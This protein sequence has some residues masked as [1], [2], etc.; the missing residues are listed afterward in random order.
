MN[1]Y[2]GSLSK[3]V[4]PRESENLRL[5][6]QAAREG[7]VLLKNNDALPLQ[8]RS[9]ALYGM[10]A[11][12]TVK[13]GTGSGAVQERHSVSIAEG[14][15][16]AGY[17][18]TTKRYLDDYDQT[19]DA[20]YQAWHKDVSARVAG[21]PI[22]QAMGE[23]SI[24]GGF[25]WP[26]G[27]RITNQDISE[28]NTDTAIYILARQAGEGSDRQLKPGDWYLTDDEKAN[29]AL[30][31]KSYKH[32]IVVIN[33]GGQIDLS[34]MDEIDGIDALVFFVQGGMAGGD[35]LADV[36]SGQHTFC[37]KLADTWAMRYED[38]PF[39]MDYSH[40][41]GDLENEDYREGIYVGYRYFDTFKIKPR[42]PFGFGLSY[43]TFD[44]AIQ[45]VDVQQSVVSAKIE[46]RNTGS[47]YAGKEVVQLYLSCPSGEIAREAKSLVAFAKTNDLAPGQRQTL[48][49]N[50][51]LQAAAAYS[52]S[53]QAWLLEAGS[54][55]L[56][57][58]TSARDVQS[59]A[60][61]NLERNVI[62]AQCRSSCAPQVA[63]D[64]L[65]ASPAEI[66]RPMGILELTIDPN[67][68]TAMQY[69]YSDPSVPESDEQ[70]RL[71]DSF[72][73][74][75]LV[76]LVVGGD[77]RAQHPAIHAPLGS[78]GRTSLDLRGHGIG[79]IAFC[80]GPAGVNIIE[81]AIRIPS[82]LEVPDKIPEKYNFGELAEQA[83]KM[84]PPA[85][86]KHVY[87]FATAWPVELLLA[88][89]WDP[90][91]LEEI[92]RGVGREL[93]E[94][95]VTL[96]LAPGMNIH[97]N[98]LCGRN[99][100]YY[101]EDPLLTG[102]MAAA[103]TRGVQAHPGI[104]TTVK[105]FCCNNQ[106]NNRN[107]VSSNVSERALREI[108][109]KGFEIA[110]R[111]FQP[112]AVMSSYNRLNGIYTANRHDL[113][114][115]I[116]RCEWGFEGLVMTDWNSCGPKAA[117]PADCVPAGN[118]LIMPGSTA[119]SEAILAASKDGQIPSAALRRSAARVLKLILGS[120]IGLKDGI[121]PS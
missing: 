8:S 106:E 33:V 58:G 48:T 92:G 94:F 93:T 98:P 61:L 6:R 73:L 65:E 55:V 20:A 119:D 91:L 111:E 99:F 27:R 85:D 53:R 88:Q 41:N 22:M 104:G 107:G 26:S 113:L 7:F 10:G 47:Q 100:E 9:I 35:A 80:D 60:V 105:H 86:G 2:Y 89:T 64:G 23:L 49:L 75:E 77:L 82:G 57:A 3:A 108:Y 84:S 103:T 5:A 56:L 74:K 50:F 42:Y 72:S 95:G 21:M 25:Q 34:W 67:A 101:S 43:T 79:N 112:L 116:L 115:D 102:R 28:S 37:G 110:V 46:V 120:G 96:W 109:L 29:L 13:G 39:A 97:R 62:T 118:D 17:M 71:L 36:L 83:R 24:L 12:K 18:I 40:L 76:S 81:E 19:Y 68:F 66:D 87:R 44:L 117:D 69:D 63:I 15:E 31:A 70:K 114:T 90:D 14:L 38:I 54:Y 30:V 52:E 51:D 11:R 59:A 32:T 121:D 4:S 78:C 1:N 16:N 45:S